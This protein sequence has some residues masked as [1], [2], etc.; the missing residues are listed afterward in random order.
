LYLPDINARNAQMRNYAERTAI[1]APMQGTAADIIK[2]AMIS[3][4]DWL[5]ADKIDARI[6]MQVHDELVLEVKA[7]ELETTGDHLRKLMIDSADL[8][9]PLEV[10]VG[11]G[12]SW[13][14]A[15]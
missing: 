6:I 13:E 2:R 5:R 10:D 8:K 7:G 3:M 11:I 14:E 4:D 15:H 1:N 12:N 9:V